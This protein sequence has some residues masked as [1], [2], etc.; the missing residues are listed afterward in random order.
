MD[1]KRIL[2]IDDEKDFLTI[3]KMNLEKI[4]KYTVMTLSNAKDIISQTHAFK[5][6]VI[7]LDLLMPSIGGI[8][9]CEMLNND[10]F[11]QKIPVIIVSALEKQTDKIKAYKLG[12]VD[13]IVKPVEIDELVTKIEKAL[14]YKA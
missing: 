14:R 13:Y 11:A 10:P 2:I 7:F 8:E 4:D 12:V 1:K 6:D 5:P 3:V 9:V